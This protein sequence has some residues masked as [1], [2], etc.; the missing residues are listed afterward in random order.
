MAKQNFW[1]QIANIPN[2]LLVAKELL[3]DKAGYNCSPPI[4]E[5]ESADYGACSFELNNL[6]VKFRTAKITPTKVG[7][8]VTFWKREGKGPIQPYDSS[9][10]FD[11]L[12]VSVRRGKNLGQ[13]FFPKEVLIKQGILSTKS[14]EGKRAL[15]V[16]PPWD[17]TTSAQAQKTQKWQSEF[18]LEITENKQV[19]KALAK[20]LIGN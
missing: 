12:I 19:D 3:Y 4:L 2:D 20:I 1:A 13:F 15:R 6:S 16:Y 18:F 8:F 14:K 11:L 7:Q 10:N 9:D 17:K 5:P